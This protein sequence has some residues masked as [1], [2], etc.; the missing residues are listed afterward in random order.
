MKKYI[1]VAIVVI[2]LCGMYN[3]VKAVNMSDL[4]EQKDKVTEELNSV[5]EGLENIQIELTE[6]LEALNSV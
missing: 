4:Q 6:A 1:A 3:V 5:N 2:M